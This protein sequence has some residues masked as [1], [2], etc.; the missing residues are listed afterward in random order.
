M[1]TRL[2]HEHLAQLGSGLGLQALLIG[3]WEPPL[4]TSAKNRVQLNETLPWAVNKP[5]C[6]PKT[7]TGNVSWPEQHKD[8]ASS[9]MM[10]CEQEGWSSQAFSLSAPQASYYPEGKDRVRWC[11]SG[12]P[13]ARHICSGGQDHHRPLPCSFSTTYSYSMYTNHCLFSNVFDLAALTTAVGTMPRHKKHLSCIKV[14]LGGGWGD[15]G[16]NKRSSVSPSWFPL[17]HRLAN[18]QWSA[19]VNNTGRKAGL[20]D[21]RKLYGQMCLNCPKMPSWVLHHFV[22]KNANRRG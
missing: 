4:L 3:T 16:V 2:Y 12:F 1:K 5:R 22:L 19:W 10:G 13:S 15:W 6:N 9:C 20:T 11:Y 14:W 17:P 7:Q 8:P 21:D 18:V